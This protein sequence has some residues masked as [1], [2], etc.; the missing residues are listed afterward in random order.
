ML[1]DSESRSFVAP[2]EARVYRYIAI[3]RED[4]ANHAQK[5]M[6]TAFRNLVKK[7]RKEGQ[8]SLGSKKKL[9]S[10]LIAK[11]I[12]YYGRALKSHSGEV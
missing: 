5:C 8:Q 6:G 2:Q 3:E 12:S 7:Q 9:I 11:L 1:C 10:Y 4:C